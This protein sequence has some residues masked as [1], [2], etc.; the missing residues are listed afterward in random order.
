MKHELSL[1]REE[2]RGRLTTL[3]IQSDAAMKQLEKK[4]DKVHPPPTHT[5]VTHPMTT[6]QGDMI[7]RVA[8][9]SRKL[10]TEEEKVLPFYAPS[11]SP[12]EAQTAAAVE[13]EPGLEELTK[14]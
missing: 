3:T 4:K 2:E 9:M 8:E 10:E 12:E 7:L 11:L 5:H 13:N 6:P 1:S 14:V